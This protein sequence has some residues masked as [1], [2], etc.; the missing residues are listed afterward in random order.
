V[1]ILAWVEWTT[2]IKLT[3]DCSQL[4]VN[5]KPRLCK[6]AGFSFPHQHDWNDFFNNYFETATGMKMLIDRL[7]A[8]QLL[9]KA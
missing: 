2:K 7:F 4:T 9:K 3:V 6:Q 1:D 5:T 8:S